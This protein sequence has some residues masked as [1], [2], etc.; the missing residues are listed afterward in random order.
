VKLASRADPL[1]SSQLGV[2]AIALTIRS[3]TDPSSCLLIGA[4]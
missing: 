4:N 3:L 1:K 2:A